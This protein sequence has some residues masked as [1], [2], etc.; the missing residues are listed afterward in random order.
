L[1]G[2]FSALSSG[3]ELPAGFGQ[4]ALRAGTVPSEV[5]L[6]GCK[7]ALLRPRGRPRH[8]VPSIRRTKRIRCRDT[9]EDLVSVAEA[10]R[11]SWRSAFVPQPVRT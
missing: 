11:H 5:V 3:T 7:V 4:D 10:K 1:A 6:A 2:A 8:E 9:P